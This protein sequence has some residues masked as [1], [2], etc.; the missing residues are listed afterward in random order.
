MIFIS[1]NWKRTNLRSLISKT[2]CT[3]TS[4]PELA[5][6]KVSSVKVLGVE[7]YEIETQNGFWEHGWDEYVLS[8]QRNAITWIIDD[9]IDLMTSSDSGICPITFIAKKSYGNTL[10]FIA[11]KCEFFDF[12]E[13]DSQK[14]NWGSQILFMKI[15]SMASLNIVIG[16]ENSDVSSQVKITFMEI[17]S[18]RHLNYNS[19]THRR[20][21]KQF[22]NL[23]HLKE[24]K[25]KRLGSISSDFTV[26][27]ICTQEKKRSQK[28]KV[29]KIWLQISQ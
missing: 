14:H 20:S 5:V 3:T 23:S 13:L 17:L 7:N 9:F 22:R 26:E 11:H 24:M 10:K 28:R 18:V 15:L 27:G 1:Q 4:S 21:S 29:K 19:N 12:Q 8:C 2:C 16:E 6:S 25:V